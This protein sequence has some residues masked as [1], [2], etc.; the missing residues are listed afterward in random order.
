MDKG[1]CLK[2]LINYPM[3]P[4]QIL[5]LD[6]KKLTAHC[7]FVAFALEQNILQQFLRGLKDEVIQNK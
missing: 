3:N 4:S 2:H 1:F 6:K 7:A 5:I